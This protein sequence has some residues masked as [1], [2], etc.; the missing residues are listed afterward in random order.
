MSLTRLPVLLLVVF[1]SATAVVFTKHQ[2]RERFI[3][4]QQLAGER[5]AMNVEW[6]QLQIEQST[7]TMHGQVEHAARERLGMVNLTT[8]NTVIIRP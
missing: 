7:L 6:G 3:D 8:A 2:A 4:L 1:A 5:D